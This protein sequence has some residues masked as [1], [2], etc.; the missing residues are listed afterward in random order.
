[1]YLLKGFLDYGFCPEIIRKGRRILVLEIKH[2]NLRFLTSSAYIDG[3]E[4][5]IARQFEIPFE[6][7]CF[8]DKFIA[9]ENFNYSG[10]IPDLKYFIL[11]LD[12]SEDIIEKQNYV[13]S[14]NAKMKTWSFNSEILQHI[15][16][17]IMLLLYSFLQFMSECFD[18]QSL[19]FKSKDFL[20][21]I[22]YP[23]CSLGSFSYKLLKLMYL[24][25]ENLYIVKNEF[26][27][28]VRNVSKV[29]YE[30]TSFMQFKHP[31][32]D[33]K[34][35]FN[36]PRGQY[37]FS[38]CIVPDLYSPITLECWFLQGCV[39]HGHRHQ[40]LI[41]SQAN[42][43]TIK[44]FGKTYKELNDTFDKKVEILLINNPTKIKKVT[45]IWECQF[46]EMKKK[47]EEMAS[48]FRD[49]FIPHKLMRLTPRAALRGAF[50]DVFNL[51]FNKMLYPNKVLRFLDLN[52]HYG[53]CAT[54][55]KFMTGKYQILM[56]D[57]I[58]NINLINNAFFI[59][60]N[61]F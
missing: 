24:N 44:L 4:Y 28:P 34:S 32:W 11:S 13:N 25:D 46:N 19:C 17:K 10:K 26:Y 58:K 16:Q 37:Y 6:K 8:P 39:F 36:N 38:N 1:M 53:F 20:N 23:L 21:P 33:L 41:D 22:S 57:D 40:C 50:F 31:E 55:F 35:E 48:F 30:F 45:L 18:F 9:K 12:S 29:E 61:L 60:V 14:F 56:G 42:D 47:K 2:L 5:E 15:D 43:N 54:K 49:F 52:S 51:K 7:V 27:V 3:T 59:K